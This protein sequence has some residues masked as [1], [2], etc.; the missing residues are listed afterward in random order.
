M[1]FLELI[2]FL[3]FV[4]D[5]H[6]LLRG[7]FPQAIIIHIVVKL[8]WYRTLAALNST[9]AQYPI[10]MLLSHNFVQDDLAFPLCTVDSAEDDD[11][12]PF[13]FERSL[14]REQWHKMTGDR[15]FPIFEGE[16]EGDTFAERAGILEPAWT[17]CYGKETED[18]KSATQNRNIFAEHVTQDS[19]TSVRNEQ[20][21]DHSGNNG[22]AEEILLSSDDRIKLSTLEW[23][24]KWDK[25]SR[26][27]LQKRKSLVLDDEEDLEMPDVR[28]RGKKVKG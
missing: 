9:P 18:A 8:A 26:F 21:D 27:E 4:R 2:F 28:S 1:L 11:F 25:I 10:A 12:F 5:H 6:P 17:T 23:K 22:V 19:N 14:P 24:V 3:F 7:P 16:F 20:G 15:T 13:G